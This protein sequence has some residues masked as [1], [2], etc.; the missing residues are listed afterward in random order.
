MRYP[1]DT[2]PPT[3]AA[4]APEPA[5]AQ[6][7]SAAAASSD[8]GKGKGKAKDG[9]KVDPSVEEKER[10]I[11]DDLNNRRSPEGLSICLFHLTSHCTKGDCRFWHPEPDV[12]KK[13]SIPKKQMEVAQ[14]RCVR[15][16]ENSQKRRKGEGKGGGE[17]QDS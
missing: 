6:E 15:I 2:K 10:K 13:L 5:P 17:G 1:R 16:R 8:K 11:L 4:P 9:D 14:R 3:V 12:M 7:D